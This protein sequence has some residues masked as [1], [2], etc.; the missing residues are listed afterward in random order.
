MPILFI[1][2]I[3]LILASFGGGFYRPTYRTP[4]ISIGTILLIILIL[5]LLGIFGPR[6]F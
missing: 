2:L 3:I 4:G 1:L 5:W 6:P